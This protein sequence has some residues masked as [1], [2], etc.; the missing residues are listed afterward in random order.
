MKSKYAGMQPHLMALDI[1]D[2]HIA[3]KCPLCGV[4]I[5]VLTLNI[6]KYRTCGK[7]MFIEGICYNCPDRTHEHQGRYVR[8]RYLNKD[9]N[10]VRGAWAKE[11]RGE[12]AVLSLALPSNIPIRSVEVLKRHQETKRVQRKLVNM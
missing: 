6:R 4:F 5:Q 7:M 1:T 8:L 3:I 11:K 10:Q 2:W 9:E 12:T